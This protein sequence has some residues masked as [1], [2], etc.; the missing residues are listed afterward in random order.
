MITRSPGLIFFTVFVRISTIA[1][2]SFE[3]VL[4]RHSDRG[5][6]RPDPLVLE[7]SNEDPRSAEVLLQLGL[8]SIDNY[9]DRAEE[10]LEDG[11][12][13]NVNGAK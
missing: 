5:F 10:F 3:K 9:F 4:H 13:L 6:R 8:L 12:R 7:T 11:V 2:S 1:P